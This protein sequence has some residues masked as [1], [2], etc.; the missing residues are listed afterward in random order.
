MNEPPEEMKSKRKAGK[1][2]KAGTKNRMPCFLWSNLSKH[3]KY[4]V[5]D[6]F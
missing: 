1:R 3:A 5:N 2:T 4:K 6:L